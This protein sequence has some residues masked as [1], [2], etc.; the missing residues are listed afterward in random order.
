MLITVNGVSVGTMEWI[1]M[2]ELV[3]NTKDSVEDIIEVAKLLYD[4]GECAIFWQVQDEYYYLDTQNQTQSFD[5]DVVEARV[6]NGSISDI[7][8][9]LG[10]MI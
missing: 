9:Y 6:F 7:V 8:R 10:S 5:G 2:G 1:G 3:L 4:F